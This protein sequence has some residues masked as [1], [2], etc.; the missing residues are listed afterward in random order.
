[1]DLRRT[2]AYGHELPGTYPK[3]DDRYYCHHSLMVILWKELATLCPSSRQYHHRAYATTVSH[4]AKP[5]H[6]IQLLLKGKDRKPQAYENNNM[7][8]R[9]GLHFCNVLPIHLSAVRQE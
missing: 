8:S 6:Q 3:M 4:Q 7:L 9:S 2:L 1:M 5:T